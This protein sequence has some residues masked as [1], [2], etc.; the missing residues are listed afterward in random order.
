MACSGPRD[1][2]GP[3]SRQI[4]PKSAG[5]KCHDPYLRCALY[6]AAQAAL[7]IN[8]SCV[9]AH[10]PQGCFQL[11]GAAFGWADADYTETLTLCT[12]LCEDEIVHGGEELLARTILEA[13]ELKV[14][15]L[16]VLTACGPEIVGDDIAAVCEELGPQVDFKLVPIQCAGFHGDQNVGTDIAL[17]AILKHLVPPQPSGVRIPR[18]VV[19]IAPFANSNP[20]WMGDLAWVKQV[21]AEMG[22][23]VLATLTHN[24]TLS[25]LERIPQAESCLVLSHDAGQKAADYLAL[26]YGITQWCGDIPLP[27][28]FGNTSR[29]LIELGDRLGAGDTSRRIIANGEKQVVEACRRRGVEISSMH[30]AP[31]AIIADAT[32]G[33]PLVRMLT[34]DLEI[35]PQVVALRSG[36]AGTPQLLARELSELDLH[37]QVIYN[38]DVYHARTAL[39][40][41]HPDMVFGSNI[42]KHAVEGLDIPFVFRL[43][44]PVSQFRMLDRAYFGYVGMLNLIEAVQNDYLDRYRS[45]SL[46]YQARW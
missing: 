29:W 3:R 16:F 40:E 45:K 26:H 10:S 20:T 32:I 28:G 23:S 27:L 14:P 7:G 5:D 9:L 4:E 18:S 12:K 31:A 15:V 30:R 35:I 41:A 19:L 33:I 34:E 24:T 46:R 44:A 17:E 6:G 1:G 11:V 43:V 25:E 2:S 8:G 22:A 38:C 21:L 37:P 36:Q 13:R 39:A 42:E